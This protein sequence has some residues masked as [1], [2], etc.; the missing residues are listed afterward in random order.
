MKLIAMLCLAAALCGCSTTLDRNGKPPPGWELT[1]K[2]P[3]P[4]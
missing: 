1:P 3:L 4:F 2:P